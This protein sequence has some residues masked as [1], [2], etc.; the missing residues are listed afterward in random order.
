MPPSNLAT[1]VFVAIF[2][3]PVIL[4]PIGVRFFFKKIH[5]PVTGQ[6]SIDIFSLI[7]VSTHHTFLCKDTARGDAFTFMA[8][9]GVSAA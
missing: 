1:Y 3:F 2:Q 6:T 8:W 4:R 5:Q 9:S 7:S